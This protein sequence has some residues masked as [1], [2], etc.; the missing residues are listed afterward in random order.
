MSSGKTVMRL[1]K[2]RL[3]N[4]VRYFGPATGLAL[5]R[6]ECER[7]DLSAYPA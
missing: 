3:S 6:T 5:A 2:E 7:A 4:L 1:T